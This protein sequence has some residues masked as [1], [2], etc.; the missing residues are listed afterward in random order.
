MTGVVWPG[1]F[2][3]GLMLELRRLRGDT[4][5]R[6][7]TTWLKERVQAGDRET[8]HCYDLR[9]LTREDVPGSSRHGD[10]AV[11]LGPRHLVMRTVRRR[12]LLT[13][14]GHA[15]MDRSALPSAVYGRRPARSQA[16]ALDS[17][18]YVSHSSRNSVS[19]SRTSRP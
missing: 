5:I 19:L 4:V 16:A 18:V 12:G 6:L 8:G 14:D 15:L 2:F 1:D 10:S 11:G 7:A 17:A 13:L 3:P 9:V